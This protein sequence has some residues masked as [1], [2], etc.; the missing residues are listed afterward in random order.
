MYDTNIIMDDITWTNHQEQGIHFVNQ[1]L[2]YY[3]NLRKER[4]ACAD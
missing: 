3:H 2:E 1:Y 4:R